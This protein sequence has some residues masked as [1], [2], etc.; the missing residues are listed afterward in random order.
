LFVAEAVEGGADGLALG[1][2]DGGLH[3]NV[4]SGFHLEPLL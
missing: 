1:I 4:D 2:E 3:G